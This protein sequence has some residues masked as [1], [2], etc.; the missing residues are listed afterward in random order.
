MIMGLF[1]NIRFLQ[2]MCNT[3]RQCSIRL[4]CSPEANQRLSGLT[5]STTNTTNAISGTFGS[6]AAVAP[7]YGKH[8]QMHVPKS[9]QRN[10]RLSTCLSSNLSP[11]MHKDDDNIWHE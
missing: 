6:G 2:V 10:I 1:A 5:T 9:K 3:T 11:T 8:G 4:D 7:V